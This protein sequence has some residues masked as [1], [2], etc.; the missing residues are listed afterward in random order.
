VHEKSLKRTNFLVFGLFH[1]FVNVRFESLFACYAAELLLFGFVSY[2]EFGFFSF[3][4]TPQTG[5]LGII[6]IH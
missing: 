3:N 2:V 6:F 1:A 5:S 4:F